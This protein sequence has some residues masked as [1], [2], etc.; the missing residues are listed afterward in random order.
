MWTAEEFGLMLTD[1]MKKKI[2]E[3]CTRCGNRQGAC[4]EAI[5]TAQTFWGWISDERLESIAGFLGMTPSE[6]DGV[7]SFYN[8]IY[9]KPV[10]KHIIMVC[11]SVSC[12]VMGYENLLE[13][14]IARLGISMGGTTADGLFTMIPIQCLGACHQ[15]PAIMID[16]MLYT[17][18]TPEKFDKII[19]KYRGQA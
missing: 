11:D 13:H 19:E 9:R 3:E 17:E 1:E 18:L 10:G 15:A 12:W 6:L 8:H 14:M 4:I 2:E 16:E 7:T 5:Q